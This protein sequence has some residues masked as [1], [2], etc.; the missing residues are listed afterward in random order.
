MHTR[1]SS[2][3][4]RN[5]SLLVELEIKQQ[6]AQQRRE[7]IERRKKEISRQWNVRAES[8]IFYFMIFSKYNNPVLEIFMILMEIPESQ[9]LAYILHVSDKYVTINTI[10]M[11]RLSVGTCNS[12]KHFAHPGVSRDSYENYF[13]F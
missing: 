3:D 6:M 8:V 1:S 9:N 10:N 12:C 7:E 4:Q 2:S 13:V 11:I 5:M